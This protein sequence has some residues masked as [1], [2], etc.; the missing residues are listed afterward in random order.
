M[1][2]LITGS[3][4]MV[5]KNLK[6]HIFTYYNKINYEYLFLTSNS[7][8]LLSYNETYN[9][10][11]KF[12]PDIVVHLAA[13]VGGLYKNLNN[14]IQ[15]F[16][17]NLLMNM[18]VFK[19]CDEFNV[20][21]LITIGS[22]CIFPDNISYPLKEEY[23]HKGKPH[24]SN[25]GYSFAKRMLDVMSEL[26]NKHT[27]M[28]CIHLIPC[29]LYGKY[30]NFNLEQ[31][32][33]IP[34]LIH[35]CYLAKINNQALYIK[36]TGKAK[37]QFLYVEDFCDIICKFMFNFYSKD[38][39]NMTYIVAPNKEYKIKDI[40][41]KIVKEFNFDNDIH[42]V[43]KYSDGQIKKTASNK[44]LMNLLNNKFKFIDIDK[45]LKK[46]IDW[47]IDEYKFVRK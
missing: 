26:Y 5:G 16:Q 40:V 38:K 45:G 7:C 33:V 27:S 14:N 15:M 42:Y 1:K 30:D 34:A 24:Q 23:L 10:F 3:T 19:V 13:N 35:K 37:R 39:L 46:T 4:G 36:G 8:N 9:V 20:K 17:D 25:Y 2:I 11:N 29:N 41:N 44:N 6:E 21:R 18:N 47:F 12:K 43:S 32:H 28:E 22:T 31:S